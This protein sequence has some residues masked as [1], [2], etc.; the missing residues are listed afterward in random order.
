MEPATLGE[1][2]ATQPNWLQ[3]WVMILVI[4]HV[5][6]IPFVVYR[7]DGRWRVRL[8]ALAIFVSFLV[9][10]AFMG[11]LYQRVGYVRL[12][13]LPHLLF[14]TPV[15]VW[16]LRRRRDFAGSLF[17]R[18]LPLYLVVAGISLVVDAVDVVRYLLGDGG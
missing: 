12:L 15:Y 18:Y 14:W 13:G 5:L 6:A 10:G 9:A 1:A 11:W 7:D 16:I 17:G 3:G 2:I 8:E 4:T